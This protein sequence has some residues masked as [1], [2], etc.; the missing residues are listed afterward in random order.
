[1]SADK[2]EK[3]GKD[4]K[5]KKESLR[6][7][8]GMHDI[9]PADWLWWG[10][11]EDITRKIA[12]FYGFGRIET[13]TLEFAEL[14]QKN[15]GE[16]TDVVTKE[17]YTFGTKGGDT[18][19]LRPE[20]T[21]PVVRAYLE[22]ALSKTGA[23]QKLYYISRMFRHENPQAGRYRQFSQVG[24]EIVGGT[25][26][27]LYDAQIILMFSRL[28]GE[29]KV[30]GVQLKM[31]S[32]GCR[33]CRPIYKRHLQAYYAK[34]ADELCPDCIERLKTNPLR[35]LDCKNEKCEKLKTGAPNFFDKLC[36]SCSTHLKTVL[37]YLEELGITYSLDN[38]L[39]RGFDYYSRT[40]FEFFAETPGRKFGALPAGGRYDYLVES[41]GGRSTPAVGGA[42]GIERLIDVM[43][44]QEIV[45]PARVP[46]KVFVIHV[47]EQ[48]K[49]QS[50]RIIEEL[51]MAGITA[52]EVLSKD[53]LKSQ[54]K[55][56]DREGALFAV[57]LGQREIFE[58]SV[59][60]RDLESGLQETVPFDKMIEELKKRLKSHD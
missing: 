32:M 6:T 14:F 27:P 5:E 21:A 59:I 7:P 47:G 2:Q 55:V 1:M 42:M 16:S 15:L 35:L 34:H 36:S 52:R 10:H 31:N 53:S 58:K 26:D 51:R 11:I 29:M 48:A 12:D 38:T 50:L 46:K 28:L 56:A 20:G 40:V 30:K 37:E 60:I 19:A 43:K 57:I 33:I 44:T 41:L 39:V 9:L 8:K 3:D 23:I 45:L 4:K 54:M 24:F 22:H 25:S 17:M 13:S 49:K 18:L